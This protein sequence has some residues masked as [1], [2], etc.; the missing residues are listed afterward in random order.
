M[1]V[2]TDEED[3]VGIQ[4]GPLIDCMFLLLIFFLVSA[5]LKKAHKELAIDLPH[6]AAATD[7]KS[8]HQTLIIEVACDAKGENVAI[9]LDSQPV[10]QRLLHKLLQEK[11]MVAPT[12]QVRID[13]DRRTPFQHVVHIL[14]ACQFYGLTHVGVRARD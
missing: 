1:R 4:M 6:S 12:P 8:P 9:Y 3:D 14:D 5:T 11:A 13:A 2:R 7:A 10:T